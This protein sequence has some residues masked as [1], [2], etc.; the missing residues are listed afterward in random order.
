MLILVNLRHSLLSS[1][2]L[3]P[4]ANWLSAIFS[5]ATTP[6]LRRKVTCTSNPKSEVGQIGRAGARHHR[7][8]AVG[9]KCRG[10]IAVCCEMRDIDNQRSC[11]EKLPSIPAELAWPFESDRQP[12]C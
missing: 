2:T 9:I 6:Q 11:T 3:P 4:K 8:C 1:N 12:G 5:H 10:P 7:Y